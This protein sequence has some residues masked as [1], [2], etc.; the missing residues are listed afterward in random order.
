M[1][2]NKIV[3]IIIIYKLNYIRVQLLVTPWTA[4]FQA[5]LSTRF[6]RQEHW[7]GVPLPSPYTNYIL[8]KLYYIIIPLIIILLFNKNKF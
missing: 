2:N 4:A 8:Y 6:S 5:P 1:L 7:S 3:F